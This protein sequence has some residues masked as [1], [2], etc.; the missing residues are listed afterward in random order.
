[1]DAPAWS[2]ASCGPRAST[3]CRGHV[4]LGPWRRPRRAWSMPAPSHRLGRASCTSRRTRRVS[5]ASRVA[6][7][8]RRRQCSP[9][10]SEELLARR[11]VDGPDL[12]GV[13]GGGAW[14]DHLQRDRPR[15]RADDVGIDGYV[16][17]L[18]RGLFNDGVLVGTG[19]V[20][21][22][23]SRAARRED[24]VVDARL[25]RDQRSLLRAVVVALTDADPVQV[26]ELCHLRHRR[27]HGRRWRSRGPWRLAGTRWRS[28]SQ[29][30]VS[31]VSRSRRACTA[32][33]WCCSVTNCC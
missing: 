6:P 26:V 29:C 11:C 2:R 1:M 28:G 5:R 4:T 27:C 33:G 30:P 20:H 25:E 7:R 12:L 16:T 18:L 13:N 10:G 21:V 8:W 17:S 9:A 24:V 3:D 23:R 31:V 32:M 22:A 14:I 19:E 15:S